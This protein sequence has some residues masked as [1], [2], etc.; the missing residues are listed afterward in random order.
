MFRIA[1]T[2]GEISSIQTLLHSLSAQFQSV[3]D[4]NFLRNAS[5]IAHQLPERLRL[6]LNDFKLQ[7]PFPGVCVISGYPVDQVK[8]GKTPEHWRSRPIVSPALEEE[9]WLVLCGSLL[10]EVFGWMTQQ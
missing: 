1:L 7:E 6:F 4:S 10:G 3:E 2:E 8:I 5:V 9:I